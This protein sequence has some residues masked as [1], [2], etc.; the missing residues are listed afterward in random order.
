MEHIAPEQLQAAKAAYQRYG[1]VTQFKN[2]RGEPMPEFQCLP[3]K[4]QEAWVAAVW[5]L[6]EQA[7]E[8]SKYALEL[9]MKQGVPPLTAKELLQ[10][11]KTMTAAGPIQ[12]IKACA[13]TCKNCKWWALEANYT[14]GEVKRCGSPNMPPPSEMPPTI[15]DFGCVHFET[16]HTG[17]SDKGAIESRF[18]APSPWYFSEPF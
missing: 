17:I 7:L 6:H 11:G 2:C 15:E 5:P 1:A 4:I 3:T 16:K 12:Q 14:V 10:L 8:M 18:S 9:Q 13:G